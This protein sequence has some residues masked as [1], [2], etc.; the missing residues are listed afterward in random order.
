MSKS[1]YL[2]NVVLDLVLG[3]VAWTPPTIIYVALSSAVFN[4]N[5]TGSAFDEIVAAGATRV[6]VTNNLT[7]WPTSGSTSIKRNGVTITFPAATGTWPEARAFYLLDSLT[8]GNI[9]HGG[10]LVTPRTLQAGD[11]ASFAPNALTITED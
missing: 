8:A 5:A 11:T 7:N 1:T 6:A 4:E 10:N 3:G 2:E 9:L